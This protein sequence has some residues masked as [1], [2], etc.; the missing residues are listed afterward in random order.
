MIVF[1]SGISR[2]VLRVCALFLCIFCASFGA[3]ST[4]HSG[5][6]PPVLRAPSVSLLPDL[7]YFIDATGTMDVEEAAAPSN[8]QMFKPL[9]VKALPRLAGVMWLR[10]TLAPLPAGGRSQALLLD[11]GPDVPADPVLYQPALSPIA[12]SIE[13]REI[14][15]THRNV[16]LLPEPGAEAITCYIRLDGLPGIWFSPT[17]RT[18]QDAATNWGS[19]SGTAALLALGVVMLL[20]LL[21]GLSERGQWRVWTALY[22]GVALLQGALG[23]PAYGT[24]HITLNQAVA[25]LAPGLALMLL[26]HVGRHLMRTRGRSPLLDAQFVLLSLPGAALALLPLLPGF[27]W[28]IRFLSLWPACTLIFTLSALGGSIM[29]LGGARRFLLGCLV[30]PLFVAAGIMGLDYGY[31]ANLLASAPLW[32]TALSALLIAGTGLPRDAVQNS[33]AGADNDRPEPTKGKKREPA[34]A[35]RSIAGLD[36]ALVSSG[37]SDAPISLDAP[38][39]DPNLRLLPPSAAGKTAA[40]FSAL[41][42]DI[43][44]NA[45]PAPV[46]ARAPRQTTPSSVS[47]GMWENLLRPPL[48]RLMREGAA[49]G[50]C[51]LPPAVRQYAENMINAAGDLARILDNPGESQGQSGIGE[52]RAAFNLQHLVREAHDAVTT[53]AENAGIGLAWYMPPLLGHMYEGQASALRDTLSLLLESAVRATSRGAVHLSVRRVPETADPGHLLFT[54]TD[55]GAGIPPRDR[56]TLALTRAWELAGSNNGYL[57]VECGPQ[58][59]SIAFTLRLKPLENASETDK[60]AAQARGPHMAVVAESAVARQA[61]A[62]MITNRG[63]KSTESRSMREALQCN[64]EAP[65]IMLVVQFPHHGPAEADALGRFEAEALESGL[66]V[67][68]ALAITKDDKH[69]DALAETGYTHALLDPVDA[70]A[71]AA[72]INEVLVEGGFAEGAQPAPA[73]PEEPDMAEMALAAAAVSSAAV[74]SM[75]AQQPIELSL[76][77]APDAGQPETADSAPLRMDAPAQAPNMSDVLPDLFGQ[78]TP[79]EAALLPDMPRQDLPHEEPLS[80]GAQTQPVMPHVTMDTHSQQG[81]LLPLMGDAPQQADDQAPIELTDLLPEENSGSSADQLLPSMAEPAAELPISAPSTPPTEADDALP[82]LQSLADTSA[83][84]ADAALDTLADSLPEVQSA[85]LPEDVAED[86]PQTSPEAQPAAAAESLAEVLPDVLPAEVPTGDAPASSLAKASLADEFMASAGLEGPHWTADEAVADS[87]DLGSASTAA[88]SAV[89]AAATAATSA[90]AVEQPEA[91]N[92][93]PQISDLTKQAV[94][95]KAEVAQAEVTQAEVTQAE[96]QAAPLAAQATSVTPEFEPLLWPEPAQ[97]QVPAPAD[98]RSVTPAEFIEASLPVESPAGEAVGASADEPAGDP[99]D[100]PTAPDAQAQEVQ[101]DEAMA[102]LRSMSDRVGE[103]TLSPVNAASSV[104]DTPAESANGSG[105][106]VP[107][108]AG[109]GAWDNYSLHEEWV[110]EPIPVGTPVPTARMAA[111]EQAQAPAPTPASASAAASAAVSAAAPARQEKKSYVGPSLAHPGEWVG[112]P[113]PM[114]KPAK[115]EE[116]VAP[117][118][119]AETSASDAQTDNR[120]SRAVEMPRTATGRLILKLLGSAGDRPVDTAKDSA[121]SG[122][123]DLMADLAAMPQESVPTAS[124]ASAPEATPESA[125]AA[126]EPRRAATA[127]KPGSKGNSIMNFIAGAADALRHQDHNAPTQQAEPA[128]TSPYAPETA[129]A[130]PVDDKRAAGTPQPATPVSAPSA[131]VVPPNAPR[132]TDQTIPQLVARLDA[133]MDDAQQGFKNRRCGVVGEAANRIATESDAFG[134]RVLAR[135]ARCVERAA[136]ANDMNA[137]RDLLPE[138][139]VAVERNRIGLTPRR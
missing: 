19:L 70:E 87:S 46:A 53:A 121:D 76:A 111:P 99:V 30:P 61:L 104:A 74:A 114:A 27:G 36:A 48:D 50:H 40:D 1:F 125:P 38:L 92:S 113:M 24:G 97:Q 86:L 105:F 75:Q 89:T 139:A 34:A 18:P 108:P 132:E 102:P 77:S 73:T 66:P 119:L 5:M 110:G 101:A 60:S 94:E 11:M 65:A 63:C 82:D 100:L 23:M 9:N 44:D 26:P 128:T 58:G 7:Q 4:A 71:F 93:E 29:G 22:V 98:T 123:P 41:P 109:R 56:S 115:Q 64:R 6:I 14:L 12:D 8:S 35:K 85:L 39:D 137:L 25:V 20:C 55:T 116:A 2:A 134:F 131:A 57:N 91:G 107:A 13:W 16:L 103:A 136:K 52:Q 32:G 106:D 112:E 117:Q 88:E 83:A 54:V 133:A 122:K 15:P 10:F 84:P 120:R 124:P 69:W 130:A 51:S 62:H 3:P 33:D 31:A 79:T 42:V 43:S 135:M 21:R 17:L 80:F 37:M 127:L 28:S 67:F 72:T 45:D 138:L 118:Q 90:T 81:M 129:S 95:E 49:L 68:K 78:A 96:A 126:A 59:T 47:P